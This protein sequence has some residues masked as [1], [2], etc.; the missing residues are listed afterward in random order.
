[1][2]LPPRSQKFVRASMAARASRRLW[3][4]VTQLMAASWPRISSTVRARSLTSSCAGRAR[5]LFKV[6]QTARA[7]PSSTSA[8]VTDSTPSELCARS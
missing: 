5:S 1:M 7:R 8:T 4:Y 6:S 2:L 3:K